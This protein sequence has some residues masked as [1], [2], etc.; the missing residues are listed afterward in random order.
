MKCSKQKSQN[1]TINKNP[2]ILM[3]P[4]HKKEKNIIWEKIGIQ[5][6]SQTYK[7]TDMVQNITSLGQ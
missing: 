5:C 6:V 7:R 3:M 4:F 1:K 2:F